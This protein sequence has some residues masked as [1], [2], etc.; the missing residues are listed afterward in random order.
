MQFP[1]NILSEEIDLRWFFGCLE[2]LGDSAMLPRKPAN[3]SLLEKLVIEG[4]GS[5]L[6]PLQIRGTKLSLRLHREFFTLCRDGPWR[7][8]EQ[9]DPEGVT[10]VSA[11]DEFIGEENEGRSRIGTYAT[12]TNQTSYVPSINPVRSGSTSPS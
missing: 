8:F 2:D 11:E 6:L 10:D 1:G 4:D 7:V 12:L 3:P 5:G 9:E